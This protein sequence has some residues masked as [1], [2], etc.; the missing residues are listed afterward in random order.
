MVTI[1][2]TDD[3]AGVTPLSR[4]SRHLPASIIVHA[5]EIQRVVAFAPIGLVE[6]AHTS[7]CCHFDCRTRLILVSRRRDADD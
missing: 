5:N 4:R 1:R 7:S 6:R 2:F 3:P